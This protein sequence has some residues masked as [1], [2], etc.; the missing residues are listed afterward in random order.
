MMISPEKVNRNLQER[1][2]RKKRK[3]EEKRAVQ[4]VLFSRFSL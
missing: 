2:H 3:K 1:I 4:A